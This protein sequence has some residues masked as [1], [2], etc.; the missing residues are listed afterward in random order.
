MDP[1]ERE[2]QAA[3]AE[4][5]KVR[6]LRLRFYVNGADD[7]VVAGDQGAGAEQEQQEPY[8][9][10]GVGIPIASSTLM[11]TASSPPPTVPTAPATATN[12][13]TAGGDSAAILLINGRGVQELLQ[14][15]QHLL[16]HQQS[17]SSVV[18]RPQEDVPS[19]E[20]SITPAIVA[21]PPSFSGA[22][23]RLQRPPPPGLGNN[24]SGSR[25]QVISDSSDTSDV[26]ELN[27]IATNAARPMLPQNWRENLPSTSSAGFGDENK[28]PANL[29]RRPGRPKG[30][31]KKATKFQESFD[32]GAEDE[33]AKAYDSGDSSDCDDK[34]KPLKRFKSKPLADVN[35][36]KPA[37]SGSKRPPGRPKGSKN[38][39][40]LHQ[41][42]ASDN[43]GLSCHICRE[44][45]EG[46]A[47]CLTDCGHLFHKKC[48][49]RWIATSNQKYR[50]LK[51]CPYCGGNFQSSIPFFG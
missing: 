18:P 20:G 11:S 41:S 27:L 14:S 49:D 9:A 13:V 40:K 43:S 25:V 10:S 16:S 7:A 5:A 21:A 28:A 32:S 30:S 46:G 19:T 26:Q 6:S 29:K 12:A 1:A 3:A 45:R 34:P 36:K 22:I 48:L 15:I 4:A 47:F 8:C 50:T 42:C 39:S 38:K 23:P 31:K 33:P 37:T 35:R 17:V 44:G 2:Q 51:T 24:A